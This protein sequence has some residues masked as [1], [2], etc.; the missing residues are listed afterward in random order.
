LR[1]PVMIN[2]DQAEGGSCDPFHKCR[3]K[4]EGPVFIYFGLAP[5]LPQSNSIGLN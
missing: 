5:D 3:K 2:M 4:A 1:H